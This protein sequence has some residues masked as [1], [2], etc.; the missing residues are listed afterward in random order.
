METN[1]IFI[2]GDSGIG[3]RNLQQKEVIRQ[4]LMTFLVYENMKCR[5]NAFI[6]P[7]EGSNGNAQPAPG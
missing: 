4:S 5:G 2:S 1:V 7:W 6:V 3:K